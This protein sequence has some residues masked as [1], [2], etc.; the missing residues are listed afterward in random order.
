M[1]YNNIMP[2]TLHNTVK[3]DNNH[4]NHDID[5]LFDRK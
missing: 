2:V 1:T 3:I 4:Q 5:I